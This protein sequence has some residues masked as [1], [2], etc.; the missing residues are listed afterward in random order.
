MPQ[1]EIPRDLSLEKQVGLRDSKAEIGNI[2]L[3]RYNQLMRTTQE[4]VR[5]T[6]KLAQIE[7]DRN[8]EFDTNPQFRLNLDTLKSYTDANYL[9]ELNSPE[10]ELYTI[11]YI[12]GRAY[13][14]ETYE[15]ESRFNLYDDKSKN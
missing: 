13:W 7:Q 12:V 10:L 15:L 9:A 3:P 8:L 5:K 2:D 4:W 14:G 6:Q 11:A 1:N